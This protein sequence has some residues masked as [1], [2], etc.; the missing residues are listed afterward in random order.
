LASGIAKPAIVRA[1]SDIMLGAA[2]PLTG[3]SAEF[4]Q[5]TWRALQFACKLMAEQGGVAA[6][7]G[8]K[9]LPSVADTQSKPEIAAAQTEQ[10]IQRGASVLIGC[11][12]SASTIVAT[13]VAERSAVPFITAYDIDPTITAR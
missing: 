12:Q 6:M 2:L 7:G 9:I 5:T 13:Q 8:A 4:G 11:N 10:L 1:A 3:P